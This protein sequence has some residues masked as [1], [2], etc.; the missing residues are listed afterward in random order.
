MK[1]EPAAN[2]YKMTKL[3]SLRSGDQSVIG[4]VIASHFYTSV[5]QFFFFTHNT[6]DWLVGFINSNNECVKNKRIT[7]RGHSKLDI[8][9]THVKQTF[10]LYRIVDILE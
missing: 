10:T 1:K 8:I 3:S 5:K 9:A 4:N 6:N 2:H 7:Q